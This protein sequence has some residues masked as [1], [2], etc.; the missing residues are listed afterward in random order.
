MKPNLTGYEFQLAGDVLTQAQNKVG[1]R[2]GGNLSI[3][4]SKVISLL[5]G[6]NSLFLGNRNYA[7]VGKPFPLL[8]GTDFN[9]DPQGHVIVD[10]NT[11]YPST[12]NTGLTQFGRTTP[13]YNLG[14]TAA[15]S[16][17]F[18]TITA[19]AEY[20]GGA[21]V[22]NG[23]GNTLAFTGASALTAEAGRQPFVYPNSVYPEF[24]GCIYQKY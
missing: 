4:E 17:K 13:K 11:G 15:I 6:I 14:V 10:A 12:N 8:E 9:R 5:P 20:R 2:L 24:S 7:V 19:I 1:L 3:N 16:Y 18:V 23:L 22:Y 21:V